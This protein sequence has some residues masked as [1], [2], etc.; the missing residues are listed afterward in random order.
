MSEM[1]RLRRRVEADRADSTYVLCAPAQQVSLDRHAVGLWW[2][3][4][5]GTSALRPGIVLVSVP[6]SHET[7]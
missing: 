1:R 4:W 7:R 6:K 2:L 3:R 5:I